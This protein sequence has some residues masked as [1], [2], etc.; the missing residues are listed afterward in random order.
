MAP[1]GASE[2]TPACAPI[3]APRPI[4]RWP[5]IAAWLRLQL[6]NERSKIFY[7]EPGLFANFVLMR[8]PAE[9]CKKLKNRS[10][11]SILF[12]LKSLIP[13]FGETEPQAIAPEEGLSRCWLGHH[14]PVRAVNAGSY[15]RRHARLFAV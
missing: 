12:W 5:A 4:R 2:I 8:R 7:A 1:A 14:G 6:G 3:C 9:A 15:V 13:F 10:P 11:H